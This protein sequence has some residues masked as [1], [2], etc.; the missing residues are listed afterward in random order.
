[1]LGIHIGVSADPDF[2]LKLDPDLGSH[3]NAD[4]DLVILRGDK[5]LNFLHDKY[6]YIG[7]LSHASVQ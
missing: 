1:M 7:Y 6:T 2:Y 3:A 5:K 4:P